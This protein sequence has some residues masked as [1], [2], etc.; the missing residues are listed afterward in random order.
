MPAVRHVLISGAGIAGPTLAH[1]LHRHGIAATVVERAPVIRS[2]GYAIDVRGAAVDVADRM[3]LLPDLRRARTGM[4]RVSVVNARGHRVTGFDAADLTPSGRSLEVLRGDLVTLLYRHTREHTEYVL[5][6]RFTSLDQDDDGVR[7]RFEHG[8]PRTTDLVV[9]ADG[10]HSG[11]RRLAFGPEERYRRFLHG[12]ISF[13]DVPHHLGLAD[14]TLLYNT[15]RGLTALYHSPRKELAQALFG[16]SSAEDTGIDRAS[17]EEQ[18]RML[19]EHFSG[20]GWE[21]DRLLDE[22]DRSDE[23]YFD[24]VAQIRMDRWS[25]GRVT[26]LGDAGYCPSPMTGQGTSL[27]LVGAYVL[28][29]ELARH[30]ALAPAL[31]AYEDRMRPFVRVNQDIAD[32]GMSFLAPRTRFGITARNLLLRAAPALSALPGL[33]NRMSRAAE[34]ID[35]DAPSPA[36]A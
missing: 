6:D 23:F 28:A 9:G 22:M 10:L 32:T 7:V 15:T 5:G 12:Y 19:R 1:G 27:A 21:T 24:A 25:A 14:E 13:C 36:S 17:P 2:G 8:A 20:A 31:A 33:G 26:L 3:G 4:N 29:R 30:D 16:L 11:T 34:A 35:L 18:R